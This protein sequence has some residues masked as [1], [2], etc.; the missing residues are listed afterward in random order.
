M[1]TS[2]NPFEDLV[3]QLM[4]FFSSSNKNDLVARSL[5]MADL[6]ESTDK[7]TLELAIATAL[8]RLADADLLRS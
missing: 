2:E 4:A 7:L 5:E 3:T 8:D 6:V 1:S